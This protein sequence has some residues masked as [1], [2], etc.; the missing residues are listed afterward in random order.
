VYGFVKQSGGHIKIYSELDQGTTV[1]MYLPRLGASAEEHEQEVQVPRADGQTGETILVVED[2][3][4]VRAFL[5][6]A[7]RDLG[8][9]VIKAADAEQAMKHVRDPHVSI[10]LLLTDIVMPG[11][12]GRQLATDASQLRPSLPVVFMTGYSRNAVIHQGRVDSGVDLIQKPVTQSELAVRLRSV[13]DRRKP[14][15]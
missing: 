3:P 10:D 8:Y 11:K 2:D 14:T 12:N 9:R 4:D 6:E 13:L 7:L 15:P 5:D 1:K